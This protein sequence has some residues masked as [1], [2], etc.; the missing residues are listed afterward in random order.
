MRN[1]ARLFRG[2]AAVALPA[3][4]LALTVTLFTA[5]PAFALDHCTG[6]SRV[7]QY[8][9]GYTLDGHLCLETH[10]GPNNTLL[11]SA[12]WHR[13]CNRNGAN[14]DGCRATFDLQ[15]ERYVNGAWTDVPGTQVTVAAP[16]G[17]F[18]NCGGNVSCAGWF[19]T[20]STYESGDAYIGDGAVV[21]AKAEGPDSVRFRLYD[22]SNALVDMTDMAGQAI[23]IC[24]VDP[25]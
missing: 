16:G 9:N 12:R 1:K 21:R 15:V 6:H 18:S 19:D 2:V 5:K 25:C 8:G 10:T 7:A 20:S 3:A 24:T 17:S 23:T 11:T 13:H 22:G 4:I 14:W